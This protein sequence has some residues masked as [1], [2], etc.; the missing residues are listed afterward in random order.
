MKLA[1]TIL[2][3]VSLMWL[4][5]CQ[6]NQ[7]AKSPPTKRD[8]MNVTIHTSWGISMNPG[9]PM[10]GSVTDNFIIK[11][12]AREPGK[13]TVKVGDYFL[14]ALNIGIPTEFAK[15]GGISG[16]KFTITS[17]PE[18]TTYYP[19][20]GVTHTTWYWVK[21]EPVSIICNNENKLRFTE[22]GDGVDDIEIRVKT[23][24]M[25]NHFRIWQNGQPS[26]L[27][28]DHNPLARQILRY[29]CLLSDSSVMSD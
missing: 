13:Q 3:T 5:A 25:K 19:K 20:S 24:G 12:Q 27:F 11:G 16:L 4:T 14:S 18:F 7:Q 6:Q 17:Q 10:G 21:S 23:A 8:P 28:P 1:L 15:Y 2:T 9:N 26:P 29:K 22:D